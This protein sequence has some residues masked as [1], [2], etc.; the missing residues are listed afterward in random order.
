MS[1]LNRSRQIIKYMFYISSAD[2]REQAGAMGGEC[3]G[4][5]GDFAPGAGEIADPFSRRRGEGGTVDR[6]GFAP[7]GEDVGDEDRIRLG[8]LR[9]ELRQI[10]RQPGVTVRLKHQLKFPVRPAAAQRRDRAGQLCRMVGVVFDDDQLR[11]IE[12]DREAARH[13]REIRQRPFRPFRVDAEQGGGMERQPGIPRLK[14]DPG[15]AGRNPALQPGCV[16]MKAEEPVRQRSAVVEQFLRTA[17]E[18]AEILVQ[19]LFAAD[20]PGVVVVEVGDDA[21]KGRDKRVGSVGLVNFGDEE[22]AALPRR[23]GGA[24]P[25][26]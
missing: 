18:G 4:G 3:Q 26:G 5:S 25:Q 23:G 11:R 19:C 12:S 1:L 14:A 2:D 21:E 9:G 15:A 22:L 16:R 20:A 7:G 17:G 13:A 8:Q 6:T 10:L 24:V